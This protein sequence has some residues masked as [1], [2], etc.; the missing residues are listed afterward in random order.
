MK[1]EAKNIEKD[2]VQIKRI[3]IPIDGS[4]YS[5]R[6]VKYAIRVAKDENAKI[7]CIHCIVGIPYG[8]INP[9][10]ST[11]QYYRDIKDKVESWFDEVRHIG[12]VEGVTEVKT[13]SFM[14]PHSVI[15]SILDYAA[16]REIDLIVIGTKGRTGLKRFLMGSVA[17]GVIQHAHCPVLLVR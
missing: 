9:A 16:S 12:K 15:N 10:S 14:D 8:Y 11:D 7:F 1:S 5:R 17:N 13:E 2:E 6:A 3:L 4:D